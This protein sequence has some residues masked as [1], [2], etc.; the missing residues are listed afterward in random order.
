[1]FKQSIQKQKRA[2]KNKDT[3]QGLGLLL[4]TLPMMLGGVLLPAYGRINRRFQKL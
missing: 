2:R 3:S 1:M 4:M